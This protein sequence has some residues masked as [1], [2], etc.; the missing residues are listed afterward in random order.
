MPVALAPFASSQ[1]T[2]SRGARG[3]DVSALQRRLLAAGHDV[4]AVDGRFGRRTEAAVRAW[5][6][7]RGLE[8]DGVVGRRTREALARDTFEPA[9]PSVPGRPSDVGSVA[10]ARVRTATVAGVDTYRVQG[11]AGVAF[12]SGMTVDADGSP[13]AY[14]PNGRGLDALGNAGRPGNWWGLATDRAGRPFV[15]G[16]DAPAPGYYV[17]TTALQDGRYAASDPRRYVDSE[18]VPFI[19]IPPQLRGQGVQLGDL[20][21][22]RNERTGKTAFAVVADVGPRGKLGEGSI[23][24]AEELGLSADPRRGGAGSGIS[25]V[26][27]P[28]SG[29][30]R[31]LGAESI[32]DRGCALYAAWGGDAQL[33]SATR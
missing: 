25:Y 20:V 27:F 5:Q 33:A 9:P 31:P 3:E 7:A 28:G 13:R 18:K 24:L 1:R 26:A 22:V 2:L 10:S 15:Q 14:H 6:A 8:S 23:R 32:Q 30:G 11:K 16:P 21:A 4:G 12:K 29:T 19:A 17:S